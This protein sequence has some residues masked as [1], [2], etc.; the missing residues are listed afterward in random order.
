MPVPCDN[1]QVSFDFDRFE[2]SFTANT[3]FWMM[4]FAM[5]AFVSEEPT[6][7]DELASLGFVRFAHLDASAGLQAMVAASEDV[8]VVSFRGSTE[9]EDYLNN[10][11]FGLTD[12]ADLGLVGQLHAGFNRALYESWAALYELVGG[13]AD[14]G[15]PVWLTGHSLGGTMALV[16]AVKLDL[17]GFR[18]AGVYSFGGP[19]P[20]N[21]AFTQYVLG[22]LRTRSVRVVNHLDLAPRIPPASIAAEQAARVLGFDP[23]EGW[24]AGVVQ[25]LDYAHASGLYAFDE[26]S[27]LVYRGT[28]GDWEDTLFWSER[29]EH[30]SGVVGLVRDDRTHKERHH[31]G[32]YLCKLQA[33]RG[34]LL[35]GTAPNP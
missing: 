8:T 5:R 30:V 12:A 31:P 1:Q 29:A 15:Q 6:T 7:R 32:T 18:V 25:K 11:R 22:R 33:L 26:D 2:S 20:G 14:R 17:A 19:R 16:T 13:F 27:N 3:A 21:R 28:P 24:A 4:W 34:A 35:V 9:V 10:A 23:L